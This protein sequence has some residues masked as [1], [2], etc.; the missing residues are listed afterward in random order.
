[1][2]V[3]AMTRRR[4]AAAGPIP[5]RS[6]PPGEAWGV[7]REGTFLP[8]ADLRSQPANIGLAGSRP[9]P[10]RRVMP[11]TG[12]AHHQWTDPASTITP[13]TTVVLM[14]VPPP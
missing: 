6:M 5:G 3:A 13:I 7:A 12:P 1:V 2:I 11:T 14:R 4:P 9:T 10:R 8:S